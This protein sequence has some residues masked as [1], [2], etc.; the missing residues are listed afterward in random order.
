MTIR[1]VLA[2]PAKD[3]PDL[4]GAAKVLVP[5]DPFEEGVWGE[6]SIDAYWIM[7]GDE[8]IGVLVTERDVSIAPTY[9]EESLRS[10]GNLY[11]CLIGVF[12]ARQRQGI[13]REAFALIVAHAR[14][15]GMH[16][17]QSNLRE[18]NLSSLRF[19]EAVGFMPAGRI[20]GYYPNPKEDTLVM[21]FLLP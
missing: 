6:D 21:N 1:L 14:E 18:S 12:P 16:N 11:L 20:E 7:D 13:A 3:A 8:R 17:I 4:T 2:N 9:A 15:T 10:P 19:H 5:D